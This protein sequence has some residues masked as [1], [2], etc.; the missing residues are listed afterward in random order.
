MLRDQYKAAGYAPD[1]LRMM[2]PS[3]T[4]SPA[5][6]P[7]ITA[8]IAR[9][10]L[11]RPEAALMPA[12]AR[13]PG[14][15]TTVTENVMAGVT[16][17]AKSLITPTN[18]ALFGGTVAVTALAPV[19]APLIAAGFT[20]SMAKGLFD[21]YPEALRAAEQAGETGDYGPFARIL[22]SLGLT[23]AATALTAA[24]AV[25]GTPGAVRT[26]AGAVRPLDLSGAVGQ[27]LTEGMSR[28]VGTVPPEPAVAAPRVEAPVAPPPTVSEL[29]HIEQPPGVTPAPEDL[30]TFLVKMGARGQ[31]DPADLP[32]AM[33]QKA[34]AFAGM[35]DLIEETLP[36]MKG[37]VGRIKIDNV[38]SPG[39][40]EWLGISSPLPKVLQAFKY[41]Y[42]TIGD[43]LQRGMDG[44]K[45]APKQQEFF[46]AAFN[47]YGAKRI[48]PEQLIPYLERQQSASAAMELLERQQKAVAG[49]AVEPDHLAELTDF[50]GD[51]AAMERA[52]LGDPVPLSG[53]SGESYPMPNG[54]TV[55][56]LNPPDRFFREA[57]RVL[58]NDPKTVEDFQAALDHSLLPMYGIDVP[59]TVELG[60][61]KLARTEAVGD[62]FKIVLP[63]AP[64]PYELV[65]EVAEIRKRLGD[66]DGEPIHDNN[67]IA[68]KFVRD[69][70]NA[71]GM[72]RQTH[73]APPLSSEEMPE[74]IKPYLAL[75]EAPSM[76]GAAAMEFY[77]GKEIAA[78]K[79]ELQQF[80][81]DAKELLNRTVGNTFAP[82]R[83]VSEK[84]KLA[85]TS[86]VG[87][88]NREV[89]TLMTNAMSQKWLRRTRNMS[90]QELV[91]VID[92]MKGDGE[93]TDPI[94]RPFKYFA[95]A[96]NRKIFAEQLRYAP[97][98]NFIENHF[99]LMYTPESLD[100]LERT[101]PAK[102]RSLTGSE[103]WMK[104]QVFGNASEAI[105]A[106][107][108]P[109]SY[110]PLELFKWDIEDRMKF[111]TA[112]ELWDAAFAN[113][114]MIRVGPGEK[115]FPGWKKF[116]VDDR[117]AKAY[118]GPEADQMALPGVSGAPAKTNVGDVYVE[119]NFYR[120]LQNHLSRNRLNDLPLVP[121]L[122]K[123]IQ[124]DKMVTLGLATWHESLMTSVAAGIQGGV[125]AMEG[126][127]QAS[128]MIAGRP[129]FDPVAMARS[130]F[131]IVS[132]PL[133]TVRLARLGGKAV[134]YVRDGPAWI[135]ENKDW[136]A[137]NPEVIPEINKLYDVAGGG[138]RFHAD[139]GPNYATYVKQAF[140]DQR[141][142]LGI[143][144]AVLGGVPFL[145]QKLAD[146][147]MNYHIPRLQIGAY[148]EL[149]PDILERN[150][151]EIEA[152]RVN[153][154]D[155]RRRTWQTVQY[156]AGRFDTQN[157]FWN[158]TFKAAMQAAFLSPMWKGGN[159]ALA[160][161]S[162]V[163]QAAEIG[164]MFDV[165][166]TPDPTNPNSW[167]PTSIRVTG[168]MP[169]LP[170]E[171][172]M[173]L[174]VLVPAAVINTA[175]QSLF[176]ALY[177]PT[178]ESLPPWKTDTPIED[179]VYP[180]TGKYD[181]DGHP[182][183]M[184]FPL[185]GPAYWMMTHHP[186]RD[187]L[188]GV[189]PV[190]RRLYEN[191]ANK[192]LA[193]GAFVYDPNEPWLKQLFHAVNYQVFG[194]WPV[195]GTGPIAQQNIQRAAD[196]GMGV[197]E[198]VA[199]VFGARPASA[200][201]DLTPFEEAIDRQRAMYL[202][203]GGRYKED[204]DKAA[205]NKML[206]RIARE[207]GD[208]G[209]AVRSGD[210]S[211]KAIKGAE[212][213][214]NLTPYQSKFR[215]IGLV[216]ALQAWESISP[217]ERL[218]YLPLLREKLVD[219]KTGAPKT[220]IWDGMNKTEQT[221]TR[222]KLQHALGGDQGQPEQ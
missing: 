60:D 80:Y 188:N 122:L 63:S 130:V 84:G 123:A 18:A 131:D 199:T 109:K 42:D 215:Q 174:S 159:V 79:P 161:T 193:T 177:S 140:I 46:D 82:E 77:G 183:R 58:L 150:A 118:L 52:Q 32:E 83:G 157:I 164:K 99:R 124:L 148:L 69:A 104:H 187:L 154:D 31:V 3:Q 8:Q 95:A 180:R 48:G 220:H 163:R 133:A 128:K 160:T 101:D 136:L 78:L 87:R 135:E 167:T 145:A 112:H 125:G 156:A 93:L 65:H 129:D 40:P 57:S 203:S 6:D 74:L 214:K 28:P 208:V 44:E 175:F 151:D 53:S 17:F 67:V 30:A 20:V 119:P 98:T 213:S 96:L 16:D 62:G 185:Y 4:P 50:F 33:Y 38:V 111:N 134:A 36:N 142:L 73:P 56:K 115:P 61:A 192:Q 158:N 191:F 72:E 205:A 149:I 86:R 54:E 45:L 195:I 34:S 197:P 170:P 75:E 15:P 194:N 2:G 103:G 7:G 66:F 14:A 146:P 126:M 64:E 173:L 221:L 39:N 24:H 212:H 184:Q 196:Q 90:N 102:F 19:L 153:P 68:D 201:L 116:D 113:R 23:G 10:G 89:D 179:V 144:R 94:L 51:Q 138:L 55:E 13:Q 202:P 59:V 162:A 1:D 165:E 70:V 35:R 210:F 47:Y 186:I 189:S 5:P 147:V 137:Q 105:A 176:T 43:I 127:R 132:A 211:V 29:P 97:N 121:K 172:Q 168:Y 12:P 219:P 37:Q 91:K 141:P 107:L 49:G 143:G 81:Q 198:T 88:I 190:A 106:G 169:K 117:V 178:H 85:I 110:N 9:F 100:L 120:I 217:N 222:D 26:V 155:L 25:T 108:I 216:K 218:K 171:F 181:A 21:A 41:D 27:G 22:T 182:E 152:G 92:E 206:T 166:M 207:G 11:N 114:D 71:T 204:V 139:F 200:S 76:G 209:E